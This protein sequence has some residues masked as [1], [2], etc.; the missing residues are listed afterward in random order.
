[1]KLIDLVVF[2]EHSQKLPS[3]LLEPQIPKKESSW[4]ILAAHF[5]DLIVVFMFTNI[6]LAIFAKSVEMILITERLQS[7]FKLEK[8]LHLSEPLLPMT[9]FS[10][11]FFSYF[12]NHGQTY[13]MF[14]L[15]KR[16]ELKSKS[17]RECF[18]W[19][20][21]SS[22]VCFSCG[23]TYLLKRSKWNRFKGH[24]YLYQGL[25]DVKEGPSIDL[26]ARVEE[27]DNE[28]KEEMMYWP[29]AA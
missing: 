24:D 1:M 9:L 23:L 17:F 16:V 4:K 3:Q 21:H 8:I 6:M 25:I 15:K 27:F 7:A 11:F 29:R 18:S 10:Y 13:G 22:L 26:M 14:L 2:A 19:A 28:K 20:L 12:M 5:I